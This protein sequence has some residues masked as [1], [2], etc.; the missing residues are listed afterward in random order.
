MKQKLKKGL[1]PVIATILLILLSVTAI[2]IIARAIIPFV[3]E[4]LGEGKE[5][6]ELLGGLKID[7]EG[8]YACYYDK[9]PLPG[10]E[11]IVNITIHQGD[12]EIKGFK[13]SIIGEGDSR[14]FD[15]E[16]G[17]VP[18][19]SMLNGSAV[20]ELPGKGGRKTY[21]IDTDL[22][23]VKKAVVAPVTKNGKLCKETD[24]AE[25][26]ECL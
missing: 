11:K 9:T 18:Y 6:F 22:T 10:S 26:T 15:I 2:S 12:V 16:E 17:S 5:C 1:S 20:L 24:E 21:S 4:S 25:L 13:I 7:T 19:I 23:D 8:G 3:R 14:V